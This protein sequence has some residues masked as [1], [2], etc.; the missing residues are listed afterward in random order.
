[1]PELILAVEW[2]PIRMFHNDHGHLL[3]WDPEILSMIDRKS[4]RL[5]DLTGWWSGVSVGDLD[6]DGRL[7]II[8]ANWGLNTKYRATP[9]HP[10][11]LYYGDFT[12]SGTLD[13]IEA[14]FDERMGK[15]VPEREFDALG[16]A[17]PFLRGLFPT[18]H[19]YGAAGISE[20]L[21]D[22]LKKAK[23]ATANMLVSMV[24]F[25][26]SDRFEAVPLP[27][28]A[29]FAP[30]FAVVVADFDGDGAEDVFLSQNFFATEPQTSRADAGRG[31]LLKG[32]GKGGLRTIGGQE[33]GIA[34]YGEQ[35][36][37]AAADYDADGRVD[38]AVSQNATAT[39]LYHNL[40]AKPGLRVR[41]AGSPGTPTGIGAVLRLK[42]GERF[43]PAREVHAGSGY[44][45]QDSAVQ[46]LA[47]L[48]EPLQL[49]IRWPGSQVTTADV[50][51]GAREVEASITGKLKLVR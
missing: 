44:W 24:L 5:S 51:A 36:G 29:Q 14:Y 31:W 7:D 21:G 23:Q 15:E 37:A 2:G 38:L 39:K 22:R 28:E 20:I 25:N 8:G 11:K 47:L 35:R 50:P 43:G 6:G 40:R 10:R 42:S 34:I 16:A 48:P 30:A 26:R 32:N 46:V 18:H 9:E 12:E 17:M 33:S 1:L 27:A 3:A 45:S 13:T 4:S 41:L 49:S 19:A